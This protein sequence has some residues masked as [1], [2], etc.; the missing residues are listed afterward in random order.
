SVSDAATKI[1]AAGVLSPLSAV[2]RRSRKGT[3]ATSLAPVSRLGSLG[4]IGSRSVPPPRPLS[5]P[6][7]PPAAQ[8]DGGDY[9]I[10]VWKSPLPGPITRGRPRGQ[11]PITSGRG[12]WHGHSTGSRADIGGAR[13]RRGRRA[14]RRQAPGAGFPASA[15]DRHRHLGPARGRL[16]GAGRRRQELAGAAADDRP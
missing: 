10:W 8:R 11:W 7:T 15:S 9:P 13:K 1:S 14:N 16:A 2:A 6:R 5:E 4:R 3:T 12:S